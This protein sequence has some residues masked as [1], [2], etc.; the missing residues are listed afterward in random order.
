MVGGLADWFAVTALF[1]RPLGLPIP[2]TA[3]V[4]ERKD[5]FG[6]TL[7]SFVQESFLSAD[8]VTERLRS[9]HAL[10]RMTAWLAEP[11]NA[12]LVAGRLLEVAATGADLVANDD[13]HDLFDNLVRGSR[14]APG[15]G[16]GGGAGPGAVDPGR[17]SPTPRRHRPL[18]P[19]SLPGGAW[20]R[21]APQTGKAFSV[22]AAGTGRVPGGQP[23]HGA[24]PGRAR[25]HGRRPLP[26]AAHP[27]RR[28]P[29]HPGSRPEDLARAATPR[30]GA[31]RRP[32]EPTSGAGHRPDRVGRRQEAA[33]HPDRRSRVAVAGPPG[34]GGDP[35][36]RPVSAT[37]R[38]WSPPPSGPWR[39][40]WPPPCSGSR[41]SWRRW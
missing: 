31:H 40:P 24:Q 16:P 5:R 21:P 27:D 39:A 37:T 23:V 25:R 30:P 18:Q 7:G 33:P 12:D 10:D 15:P 36:V 35:G 8:A 38:P 17:A 2:H 13:V 9:A 3:I 6:E 11:A 29:G 20:S 14:R 4:V 32:V 34:R 1:R 28:G 19:Q 26:P 41:Q 22:V